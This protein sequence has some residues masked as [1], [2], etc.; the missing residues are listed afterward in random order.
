MNKIWYTG[1]PYILIFFCIVSCKAFKHGYTWDK[2]ENS[3]ILVT[4][5]KNNFGDKRLD[6]NKGFHRN[7]DL[8]RFLG[9]N[10][11]ELPDLIYEYKTKIK[12]RGIKLFYIKRDSAF[13]FEEPNRGNLNSVIKE[14][15]KMD[16]YEK[17]TYERLKKGL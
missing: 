4:G 13:V 11:R 16:E 10:C 17:Q 6:Y 5:D 8:S 7:S 14:A 15:R 9:C 12:S 1:I 2:A 3:Y